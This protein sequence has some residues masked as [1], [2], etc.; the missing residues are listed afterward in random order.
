MA[1]RDE[2]VGQGTEAPKV[3][4][5]AF[6]DVAFSDMALSDMRRRLEPVIR[7][8]MHFYWRF[9]RG[10][11]VGARALVID[12][13]GRVFLV[14]HSYVHGWHL[15]GGGVEPG[16]TVYMA[17]AREL[18]EEGNIEIVGRPVLHGVFHNPR[19][20]PRDHIVLFVVRDFRQD[21]PPTPD[22]EIVAHGFFP[23]DALPDDATRGTRARIAE[24]IGGAAVSERW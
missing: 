13:Q 9:A 3:C 10:L 11:T 16:E 19:G 6:N 22:A 12:G 1:T 8:V 2:K 20:S 24:V 21:G 18:R 4:N 5:V 14:Q 7:R 15:P 17:L 23:V